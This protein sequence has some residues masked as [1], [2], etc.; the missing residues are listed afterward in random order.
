DLIVRRYGSNGVL[1]TS[2]GTNGDFDVSTALPNF[3]FRD[4]DVTFDGRAAVFGNLNFQSGGSEFAVVRLD[5]TG[6]RD[7]SFGTNGLAL[8]EVGDE[9]DQRVFAGEVTPDNKLLIG[10]EVDSEMVVARFNSNGTLDTTFN[11]QGS[12]TVPAG[13]F[14]VVRSIA[15][16]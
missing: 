13:D 11:G 1:D 14:S 3:E 2:Y 4:L 16:A 6:H 8:A 7:A 12:R 15:T 5:A 10:G 9:A